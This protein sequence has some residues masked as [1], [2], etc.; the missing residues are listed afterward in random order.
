MAHESENKYHTIFNTIHDAVFIH[1]AQTG[2]ILDVNAAALSFVGYTRDEIAGLTIGDLSPGTPPYD[3]ATAAQ[4]IQSARKGVPQLFEWQAKKK[5]GQ[6][7]WVEVSLSCTTA[8]SDEIV[9][10][11]VRDISERILAEKLHKET[12]RLLEFTQFTVHQA[13]IAVFWCHAT[14]FFFYVNDTACEWLQYTREELMAMHVA[15][16]NPEF[17]RTAWDD[18]WNDIKTHGLV[19]MQSIHRRKNGEIYPV[20]I[21]SNYVQFEGK[22]YKLAFVHDISAQKKAEQEKTVLEEQL[23]QAQKMEAIGTLAGGVAHDLNNMLSPILGYA[24]LIK[25]SLPAVDQR[26]GQLNEIFKAGLRARNLTRQLLTF[27][28]KQP[29]SI[30]PINLNNVIRGFE[31]MLRRTIRENITIKTNLASTLPVIDG[32]QG[33]IEQI[34]INL[35]V[36]AQDA[37]P[38]GGALTIETGTIYLD[39]KFQEFGAEDKAGPHVMM[40]VSDTGQGIDKKLLSRIFEPFFT[41][42]EKGSGTG[43][44]LSTAYG[45][46]KQ[47]GGHLW[48]YSEPGQGSTFKVYLPQSDAP[49]TAVST[50]VPLAEPTKGDETILVVEDNKQVLALAKYILEDCGYKVLEA[51]SPASAINLAGDIKDTIDLLL[52]DVVMPDLNGKELYERLADRLP[53]LKVLFMSGYT[54]NVIVHHGVIDEDINFISKPFGVSDLASKVREVLDK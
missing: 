12:E 17:P 9:V 53:D 10:A 27:G 54:G 39:E 1:D 43:L 26:W 14:G 33:Q 4:R 42:K 41:T 40:A 25:N 24:E 29:L 28:R 47:H 5:N 21:F 51:D 31:K 37:M 45:I 2:A 16:I 50:E 18:H 44:G 13:K 30:S 8:A 6:V 15:D 23:R 48:V 46:T 36:N 3:E 20:E 38:D 11:V 7:F 49:E 52:T 34:I 19:Q 32:D 35:A 22:E